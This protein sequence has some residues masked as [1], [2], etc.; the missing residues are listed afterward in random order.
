MPDQCNPVRDAVPFGIVLRRT[1]LQD[2]WKAYRVLVGID[3]D[4]RN[5]QRFAQLRTAALDWRFAV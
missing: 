3:I 5:D 4:G 1:A 2:L